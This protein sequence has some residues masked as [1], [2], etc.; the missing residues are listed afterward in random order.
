MTSVAPNPRKPRES[1]GKVENLLWRASQQRANRNVKNSSRD[2]YRTHG[3]F[4][5]VEF[6]ILDESLY[7]Q[8][9]PKTNLAERRAGQWVVGRGLFCFSLD[10]LFAVIQRTSVLVL[11]FG[12]S[13][14]RQKTRRQKKDTKKH[15]RVVESDIEQHHLA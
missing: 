3:A 11:G 8:A 14:A 9:S 2:L 12:S 15:I 7:V 13:K 4:K 10:E 6:P 1:K 5:F